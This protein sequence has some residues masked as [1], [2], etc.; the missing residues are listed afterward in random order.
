MR[1]RI[2][3]ELMG[4]AVWEFMN[5]VGREVRSASECGEERKTEPWEEELRVASPIFRVVL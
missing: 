4:S 3:L 1:T 2:A 5:V